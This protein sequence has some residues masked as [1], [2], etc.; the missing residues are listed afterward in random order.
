MAFRI[1]LVE[2]DPE[3]VEFVAQG[4]REEGYVVEKAADGHA[5]SRALRAAK[6]DLVILDWWLPGPDG[7]T[8][9]REFREAKQVTPVLFLTAR[10]AVAQRVEGLKGGAD[11]YLCKPFAFEELLARVQAL[12]RR[13][14]VLAGTALRHQDILLDPS[15]NRAERGGKQLGLTARELALLLFFIRHPGEVLSRTRLY[16]QVWEDQYDGLSNTLE[17]HVMEL[18]KKLEAHGPRLIHTVRGRGYMLGDPAAPE[19]A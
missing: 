16:E 3:I 17:V 7:F 15:S 14:S 18:R 19:S 9:L 1:L 6:W 11:D 13:P 4:L 12:L 8:L 10:D 2:D 5:G